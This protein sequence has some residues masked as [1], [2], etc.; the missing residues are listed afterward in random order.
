MRKLPMKI[1]LLVLPVVAAIALAALATAA[2]P[3]PNVDRAI[4]AQRALAQKQPTAEVWNDLG[5]LLQLAGH[6][7][8]AEHDD[9]RGDLQD[10][11]ELVADE[12]RGARLG[13]VALRVEDVPRSQGAFCGA[14]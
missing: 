5:N 4:A 11:V 8:V 2:V 1:R 6:A 7:A 9:P 14:R 3:P 13:H 10:L 12:D